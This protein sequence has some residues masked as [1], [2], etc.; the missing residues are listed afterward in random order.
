MK[1]VTLKKIVVPELEE[2]AKSYD[3]RGWRGE[4][5]DL[6]RAYWGRVHPAKLAKHLSRHT[7]EAIRC[8]AKRMGL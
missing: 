2:A 1:S 3:P 5:E 7:V 4:E 6:M 8:K